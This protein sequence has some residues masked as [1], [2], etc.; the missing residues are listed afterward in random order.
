M[1]GGVNWSE[2][3]RTLK[4]NSRVRRIRRLDIF[5]TTAEVFEGNPPLTH[6][7]ELRIP[8]RFGRL[9]G[10]TD[11]R[12]HHTVEVNSYHGT[13]TIDSVEV[14]YDGE[15]GLVAYAGRRVTFQG[16][17]LTD[18]RYKFGQDGA[19]KYARAKA[20]ETGQLKMPEGLDEAIPFDLEQADLQIPSTVHALAEG[21]NAGRP[22]ARLRYQDKPK[23]RDSSSPL[24]KAS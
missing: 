22:L 21:A 17:V 8:T 5:H 14:R 20:D 1:V 7:T 12:I 11:A 15:N 18:G 10:V 2:A 9:L 3:H 4:R 24:N 23:A 6:Y 13:S 16:K 19:L